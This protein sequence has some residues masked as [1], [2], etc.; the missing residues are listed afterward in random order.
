MVLTVLLSVAQRSRSLHVL[1][2]RC[3]NAYAIRSAESTRRY[4]RSL[5]STMSLNCALRAQKRETVVSSSSRVDGDG[6]SVRRRGRYLCA[7]RVSL[8]V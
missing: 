1:P 8:V 4:W 2:S 5:S 6:E 3:A 7:L